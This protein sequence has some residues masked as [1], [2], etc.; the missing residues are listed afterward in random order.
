[1]EIIS[2]NND[3][4][5]FKNA[6]ECILTKFWHIKFANLILL[7]GSSKPHTSKSGQVKEIASRP[8]KDTLKKSILLGQ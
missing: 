7:G 1:M 6:F 5:L 3:G 2:Q 4:K 8:K